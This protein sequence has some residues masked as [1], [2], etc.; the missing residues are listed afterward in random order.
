M[1]RAFLFCNPKYLFMYLTGLKLKPKTPQI[2]KKKVWK[3]SSVAVLAKCNKWKKNYVP[4]P[5]VFIYWHEIF[6]KIH[7]Q[8][9][10]RK[11]FA[12]KTKNIGNSPPWVKVAICAIYRNLEVFVCNIIPFHQFYTHFWCCLSFLCQ[13]IIP[14]C[15]ACKEPNIPKVWCEILFKTS[16]Y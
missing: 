2:I 15:C 11:K 3:P 6:W 4:L 5:G 16:S 1:P 8:I 9:S 7:K 13:T 12:V 10:K 14:K